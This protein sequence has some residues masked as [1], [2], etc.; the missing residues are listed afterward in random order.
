ME[1]GRSPDRVSGEAGTPSTASRPLIR[2]FGVS[3]PSWKK[4]VRSHGCVESVRALTTIVASEDGIALESSDRTSGATQMY[5][6][7]C[8]GL[9]T[10]TRSGPSFF[11][12]SGRRALAVSCFAPAPFHF[13]R[14]M[15]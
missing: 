10:T 4:F 5:S 11:C 12:T 2:R 3:P 15:R 9:I 8:R 1:S 6:G 7:S 14:T 13:A